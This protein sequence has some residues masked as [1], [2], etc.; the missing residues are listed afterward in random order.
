MLFPL[1]GVVHLLE[2]LVGPLTGPKEQKAKEMLRE[3]LELGF[4]TGGTHTLHAPNNMSAATFCSKPIEN[5][6]IH[7]YVCAFEHVLQ[8]EGVG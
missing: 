4:D 6:D 2:D 7:I 8:G 1:Q 5:G 3:D